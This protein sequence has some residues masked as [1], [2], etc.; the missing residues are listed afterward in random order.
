[1][2]EACEALTAADAS[3]DDSIS[4]LIEEAREAYPTQVPPFIQHQIACAPGRRLSVFRATE[5]CRPPKTD[6]VKKIK[7]TCRAWDDIHKFWTYHHD[8]VHCI[9]KG[10]G[11]EYDEWITFH[12]WNDEEKCFGTRRVAYLK[13]NEMTVPL[14]FDTRQEIP[15]FSTSGYD[16]GHD[17]S[18]LSTDKPEDSSLNAKTDNFDSSDTTLPSWL[19]GES[20]HRLN[21]REIW[22][23][24]SKVSTAIGAGCTTCVGLKQTCV[25][26]SSHD[27]CAY[28]TAKG[29]GQGPRCSLSC[30]RASNTRSS[31]SGKYVT[32]FSYC[33]R[34]TRLLSP[35]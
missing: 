19:Q 8:N 30:R 18:M 2:A 31:M 14:I 15:A 29:D 35:I 20:V 13:R 34:L 1:M 10:F 22:E 4:E 25:I 24:P 6:R 17:D 11:G 9:V 16:G 23:H 21:A 12:V 3:E 32:F 7:L 26:A 28:C 33:F 5:S 27:S